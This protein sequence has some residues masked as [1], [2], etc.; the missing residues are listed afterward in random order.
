MFK[1]VFLF[2]ICGVILGSLWTYAQDRAA[3]VPPAAPP[4]MMP[5]FREGAKPGSDSQDQSDRPMSD[6]PSSDRPAMGMPTG[7]DRPDRGDRPP[8][9]V[10]KDEEKGENS[11]GMEELKAEDDTENPLYGNPYRIIVT[12]NLFSLKPSLGLPPVTNALPVS[13]NTNNLKFLGITTIGGVV[14]SHFMITQ[15]GKTPPQ[16]YISLSERAASDG[17][18]VI[19]IDVAKALAVVKA[20]DQE[21][22][23]SFLTHGIKSAGTAAVPGQR[24]GGTNSAGASIQDR[25]RNRQLGAQGGMPNNAGGQP[26]MPGGN[27]RGMPG[28]GMGPGQNSGGGFNV[29]QTSESRGFNDRRARFGNSGGGGGGMPPM[30]GR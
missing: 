18:E 15:Q 23:V 10:K 30:P 11:D 13:L 6:R 14:K 29:P 7:G 5:P 24:P 26:N 4:G 3:S 28:S 20:D 27:N 1:R 22:A 25:M 8:G 21:L 12:R 2:I 19:S 9:E 17:L 16:Q